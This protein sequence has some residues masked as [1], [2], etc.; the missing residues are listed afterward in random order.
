M[1]VLQ[2]CP[3]HRAAKA[4]PLLS[5]GRCIKVSDY[6]AGMWFS[7]L[8]L[9]PRSLDDIADL[10]S[11]LRRKPAS[12]VIRGS[13]NNAGVRLVSGGQLIRRCH[14]QDRTPDP[15]LEDC[16]QHWCMVD[17]DNYVIPAGVTFG[18][19]SLIRHVIRDV[20]PIE[21]H[22]AACVW[23]LS[24][25]TGLTTDLLKC[26]LWFWLVEAMTSDA[27]KRALRGRSRVD[28]GLYT[29]SQPHYTADPILITGDDPF[30]RCRAGV[31]QGLRMVEFKPA[32]KPEPLV[33]AISRPAPLPRET[34]VL[35]TL[36]AVPADAMLIP[37]RLIAA[38]L[39]RR[40]GEDRRLWTLLFAAAA[41]A[42]EHGCDISEYHLE[43]AARQAHPVFDRPGV[44]REAA[45]AIEA[46]KARVSPLD[47]LEQQHHKL[48]WQL[49]QPL[50]KE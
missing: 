39:A 47:A 41:R 20:L 7:V 49:S 2:C 27:L 36:T 24:S 4:F 9:E 32:S 50:S 38:A 17:V 21:F 14:T 12:Y 18:S 42:V 45:R 40:P 16:P 33:R 1:L 30:A 25:S 22:L 31:L 28:L 5:D 48:R 44:Q 11:V 46:A 13:L 10:V 35:K 23:S 15:P 43:R 8:E 34:G 19:D 29:P 26:H 3:P 6:D 37:P